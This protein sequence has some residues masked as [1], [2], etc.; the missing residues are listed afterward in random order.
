M[1]TLTAVLKLVFAARCA[2][3]VVDCTTCTRGITHMQYMK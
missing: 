1:Q 2:L 3:T